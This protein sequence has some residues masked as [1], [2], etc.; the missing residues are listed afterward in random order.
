MKR[1]H[2]HIGVE[3]LEQSI[4]FY[5]ALFD[6]TPTV[7]EGDYAKWMLDDPRLN[8]AIS[9]GH[10]KKSGIEHVG[11]QV[12]SEDELQELRTRMQ[13][14]D[15]ITSWDEHKTHCCYANSEKTWTS[16]PQNIVWETFYS[17]AQAK[18]YGERPDV[19]TE[20]ATN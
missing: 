9:Q 2:M 20:A 1:V 14:A 16:D 11:I 19:D 10:C 6:A 13:R 7:S 12:E 3:N 8:F 4:A 15:A 17:M 5:S 18:T